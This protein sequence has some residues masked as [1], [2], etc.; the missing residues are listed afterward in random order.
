MR[1]IKANGAERDQRGQSLT[2]PETP[3]IERPRARVHYALVLQEEKGVSGQARDAL[4][5]TDLQGRLKIWGPS[6]QG[7][8][9]SLWPGSLGR[10]MAWGLSD[11]VGFGGEVFFEGITVA[12]I[13]SKSCR[14]WSGKGGLPGDAQEVD[15]PSLVKAAAWTESGRGGGGGLIWEEEQESLLPIYK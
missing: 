11:C 10:A 1:G 7:D 9:E 14:G 6:L 12:G 13:S 3:P 15:T 4:N 2:H 5:S 8:W